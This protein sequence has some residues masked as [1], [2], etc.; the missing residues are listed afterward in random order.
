MQV[1]FEIEG[2]PCGKERPRFNGYTRRVFT[3][4][5]TKN[6]ES[7]SQWEYIRQC[8]NNRFGDQ[9]ALAVTITAYHAIPKSA[10]KIKK[11]KMLSGEIRPIKKPDMDNIIKIITD[12]LNNLAYRDDSQIVE[13]TIKKFYSDHPRV[14]VVITNI[15]DLEQ[16]LQ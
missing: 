11:K 1:S 7:L 9:E 3:P 4:N 15:G 16:Q 5:K 10:S 2:E 12:S 8:K 6:Y 14:K 13:C